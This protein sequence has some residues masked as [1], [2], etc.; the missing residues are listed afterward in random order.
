MSIET[1][2]IHATCVADM[3]GGRAGGILLLGAS[4]SGKSDLA[5]R[6]IDGGFR[7]VADDQVLIAADKGGLVA[8]APQPIA[9]LLEVR[10]VGLVRIEPLAAARLCLAVRLDDAD[11]PRLP[12]PRTKMFCG[13][14]LPLLSLHPFEA[15]ASAK[16]RLASQLIAAPRAED[17]TFPFP[18]G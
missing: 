2:Q 18:D 13:V 7:L 15:S 17:V 14:R 16:I 10:G 1:A 5:L 6:L 3:R 8:R 9:G 12:R 4:G 11:I